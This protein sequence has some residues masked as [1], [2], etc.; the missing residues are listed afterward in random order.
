MRL[1]STSRRSVS[2]TATGR[3]PSPSLRRGIRFAEQRAEDAWAGRRPSS[4]KMTNRSSAA[5]SLLLPSRASLRCDG[6]KPEGPAPE[7][8]GKLR[9][10]FLSF[11]RRSRTPFSESSRIIGL[12][13]LHRARSGGGAA[14]CR[15]RRACKTSGESVSWM[16][17]DSMCLTAFDR[18]P[19]STNA[20]IWSTNSSLSRRSTLSW[21]ERAGA[22]SRAL[23]LPLGSG[24]GFESPSFH[25]SGPSPREKRSILSRRRLRCLPFLALPPRCGASSVHFGRANRSHKVSWDGALMKAEIAAASAPA[26]AGRASLGMCRKVGFG[27]PSTVCSGGR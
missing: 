18:A 3:T 26:K 25:K 27:V 4:Q 22:G 6:L 16:P 9:M 12:E 8:G 23:F 1:F 10:R 19:S 15:S 11:A 21:A 13:G 2:P 20:R 14:G 24:L 17:F 5:T 7:P